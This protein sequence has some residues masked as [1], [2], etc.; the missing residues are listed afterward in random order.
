M[1]KLLINENFPMA[2]I[3]LLK[4]QGYDVKSILLEFSGITDEEV[5]Q[6]A[7]TEERLI[8]T[9]DRDYGELIFKYG[10]KPSA[11]VI[12][13]RFK[14]FSPIFPAEY[15]ITLFETDLYNFDKTFTVIDEQSI[16]QRKY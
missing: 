11:G 12:Y 8:L 2:S 5:M 7:I 14:E 13:L 1:K 16:R 15:L 10:F 4:N 3:K 9:F 6:I